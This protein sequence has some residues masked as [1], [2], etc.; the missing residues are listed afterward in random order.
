[1][2]MFRVLPPVSASPVSW[3]QL[4]LGLAGL[5][6]GKDRLARRRKEFQAYLGVSHAY[7][8]SSGKAALYLALKALQRLS[9]RT[10][11]VVPAYTCFSV[12]SA[13]VKA[14]LR[15]VPCDV[16]PVSFDFD[17]DRLETAISAKTLCV[18]VA[19]LCGIPA[20]VQ[21]V[22]ALAARQGA[23]VIEDAAQAFGVKQGGVPLGTGGDVGIFSF[24]RGKQVTCGSGGMAVTSRSEIAGELDR[25]YAAL[26]EASR[27]DMVIDWVTVAAMQVF[28]RPWLYWI[29]ASLPFLKLGHT[30]FDPEFPVRVLS[31]MKAGIL[32]GWQR[33]LEWGNQIRQRHVENMGGVLKGNP[34]TKERLPLLRLPVLCRSRDHRDRIWEQGRAGGIGMMYPCGIH[35]IPQ[36][37]GSQMAAE[38]PG[39]S[40][41]AERIVTLPTHHV[42]S[43]ADVE[44]VVALVMD[45]GGQPAPA[46]QG[47]GVEAHTKGSPSA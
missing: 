45:D 11:V 42:V 23:F 39:A 31:S 25:L 44:A 29:P 36:L 16:D 20:D 5:W 37:A 40:A 46:A 28:L 35:R 3:W 21:R 30:V 7:P 33:Q 17:Y 2:G 9:D 43:S 24:G 13:A 27:L 18:V 41:I 34:F 38:C 32:E 47:V 19:H 15:V 1:M 8:V 6:S 10:E 12:P 22:K 26:P 14:G 4:G